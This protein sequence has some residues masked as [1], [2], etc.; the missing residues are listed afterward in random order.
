MDQSVID[1]IL[2]IEPV[3][4]DIEVLRIPTMVPAKNGVR[5]VVGNLDQP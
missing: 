1:V 4:Y 3:G 5:D 2:L